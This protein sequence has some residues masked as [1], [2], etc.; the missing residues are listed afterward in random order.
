MKKPSPCPHCDQV[1]RTKGELNRHVTLQ[2]KRVNVTCNLCKEQVSRF[3]PRTSVVLK[4][5]TA[6]CQPPRLENFTVK[7]KIQ[8]INWV[9]TAFKFGCQLCAKVHLLNFNYHHWITFFRQSSL[10]HFPIKIFWLDCLP[11]V[12]QQSFQQ[13]FKMW[14][15]HL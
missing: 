10:Y 2:H 8:S 13:A 5:S 12:N 9:H 14:V 1:C 11:T 4:K 3:P 15:L 6:R 7:C